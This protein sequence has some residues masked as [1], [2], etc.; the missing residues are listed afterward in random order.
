MVETAKAKLEKIDADD[1]GAISTADAAQ[2]LKAAAGIIEAPEIEYD[3]NGDGEVSVVDAQK[4]LRVAAGVDSPLNAEEALALFDE[5]I[6]SVKTVRPGFNKTA[7]TVCPSIKVTTMNAP[8]GDMNVTNLEFNQYVD[9]IIKLMNTFPYNLVL[10]AEM[11]AQL[12]EMRIQA[13]DSYKPQVTT[14]TVAARSNSHYSYF[15]V[16]NLGWS[17]K[18]T[19][20]DVKSITCTIENGAIVY[21]VKM[22]DITYV[23]DEYPTGAAGF[24]KR[25]SLPYGKIFNIP[26]FDESDGSVINKMSF[27][28]GTIVYKQDLRTGDS[29]SADYSYGYVVDMTAAPQEDSDLVMKTVTTTN[30]SENYVM[31]RVTVG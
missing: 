11:K 23:G 6:N 9:K 26:A 15:P 3:Y 16:N 10:N 14:K 30:M 24:S 19:M 22:N 31:N 18:L 20:A 8:I 25:Q 29:L 27:K 17:S 12:E 2:Y 28:S 7:T 4:V 21:T 13:Q 5:G 1:D